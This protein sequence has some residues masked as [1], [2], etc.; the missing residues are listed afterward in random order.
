M[1]REVFR[2]TR[3]KLAFLLE[4]VS[5]ASRSV[6]GP[7]QKEARTALASVASAA[8]AGGDKGL[9]TR[10]QLQRSPEFVRD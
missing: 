10:D 7:D 5:E 8:R 1:S 6:R 9:L 3:L 2:R 4:S